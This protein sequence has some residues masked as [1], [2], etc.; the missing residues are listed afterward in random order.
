MPGL[1]QV[2]VREGVVG[3]YQLK[4]YSQNGDMAGRG[5]DMSGLG[6]SRQ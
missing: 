1:Y 2:L 5:E 6:W 3:P 4:S